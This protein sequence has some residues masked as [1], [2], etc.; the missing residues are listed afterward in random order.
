MDLIHLPVF[1]T[2]PSPTFKLSSDMQVLVLAPMDYISD[3]DLSLCKIDIM[4]NQIRAKSNYNKQNYQNEED[5]VRE[6]KINDLGNKILQMM[7]HLQGKVTNNI[8]KTE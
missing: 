4:Q 7:S 1:I 8:N 3:I 6:N 2:N 5:E